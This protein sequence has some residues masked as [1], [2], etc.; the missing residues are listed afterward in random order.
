[1]RL[2]TFV[3]YALIFIGAVGMIA[4]RVYY[5]PGGFNLGLFLV[6]AGIALGGAESIYLRRMSF[7]FSS[8]REDFYAGT[9]ALIWG[10]TAL[11]VGAMVLASAYL[12]EE[13]LWRTVVS[14]LMRRPGTLLALL[15]LLVAGAGALIAFSPRSRGLAWTLLV[16][17]PKTILG[18]MLIVAGLAAVGLGVWETI[19]P[20]SFTRWSTDALSQ[21]GLAP[22]D[23][24]WR[25]LLGP[26]R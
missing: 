13:E 11:L 1:M 21:L 2:I 14:Y 10:W 4:A 5:L 16:R 25:R 7:R 22:F 24:H 26:L 12:M 20:R 8:F 9:P 15:G 23:H 19:D 18:V 3:E 6:G 17:V